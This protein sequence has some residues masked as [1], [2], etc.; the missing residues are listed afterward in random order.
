L[1]SRQISRQVGQLGGEQAADPKYAS[2]GAKHD[3]YDG[4]APRYMEA[5]Q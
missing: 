2:E 5:L 3:S 1:I 4:E